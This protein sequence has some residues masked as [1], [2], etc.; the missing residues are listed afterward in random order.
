MQIPKHYQSLF[1]RFIRFAC[2]MTIFALLSGILFQESTKKIPFSATYPPGIHLESTYHLALVHGHAFLIGVLIPLAVIGMLYF[3]LLLGGKT[4]SKNQTEWGS[5]LYLP[6]AFL[7]IMLMIYK[8]Y[9]YVLSVRMGQLDFVQIDHSFFGGSHLLRQIV[10]GLS[11]T[12]MS[13]GLGIL[14]IAIW[15]SLSGLK[16]TETKTD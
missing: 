15:R 5:W 13:I 1:I 16:F 6:S 4:V 11:H 14:V 3:G 10:Y 2:G 7:S 8:G 12:S 9:H